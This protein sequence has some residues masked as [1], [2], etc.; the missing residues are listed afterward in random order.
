MLADFGRA[1]GQVFDRAF[2]WVLVKA[3]VLTLLLLVGSWFGAAWLVSLL[4]DWSVSLPLL[5][6]VALGGVA[7]GAAL[8]AA[9]LASAF[10]M[11]PVAA[12]V[13][14]FFLEEIAAAVEARHYPGLAPV[15]PAPLGE[16]LAEGVKFF[17]VM[18]LANAVALVVYLVAGPAAPL[19]FWLVNGYLLGREYFQLVAL[20]RLP[21]GEA[22]A[23][24]RRHFGG[25]WLAGTAMAVPL[26]VPLLNL[27]IPI[28]GAATFTH[29]FHR[30]RQAQ[31]A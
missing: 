23:L 9:I 1:V 22:T 28:L 21:A 27:L 10:L 14:G 26:S 25:I 20:R 16:T 11:F 4:P 5:G 7:G 31:P 12:L 17:L 3:L 19:V 30:L 18:L 13:V 15:R 24:R 2:L 8:L 6:D 29:T